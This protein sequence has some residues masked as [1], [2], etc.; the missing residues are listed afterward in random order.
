MKNISF[1]ILL[2]PFDWHLRAFKEGEH[3]FLQAGP[4]VVGFTLDAPRREAPLRF[5]GP[6]HVLKTVPGPWNGWKKT[7]P[8][9]DT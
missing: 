8:E 7:P 6:T 9:N 4:I 2:T 1:G 5:T 3:R